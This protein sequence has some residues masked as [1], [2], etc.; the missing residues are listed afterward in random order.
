MKTNIQQLKQDIVEAKTRQDQAKAD[1]KRI[2]RDM[3][4]FKNNKG[5]KLAELQVPLI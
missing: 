2:E 1:V 4:E 3:D 5:G